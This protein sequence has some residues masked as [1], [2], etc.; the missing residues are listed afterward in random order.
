[1]WFFMII[2]YLLS[3][4]TLACF[5]ASGLQGIFGFHLLGANHPTFAFLTTIIYLFTESLVIFF[6]VGTGISI[7]EYVQ[8]HKPQD[9]FV[10]RAKVFKRRLTPAIML[11]IS[12]FLGQAIAGG[13]TAAQSIPS[14]AHGAAAALT[15]G[16]FL[17]LLLLQHR[18]FRENTAIVLDMTADVRADHP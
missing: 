4:L 3:F 8:E 6:F 17:Y 13:A 16:H 18:S 10:A 15:Y 5:T 14:W 1:M 2:C 9:D 11:N 12:L 7:K